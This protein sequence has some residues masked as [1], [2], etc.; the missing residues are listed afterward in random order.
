MKKISMALVA[1]AALAGMAA[2][3]TATPYQPRQAGAASAG[4]YSEARVEQDRWRITFQGNS[5]TSRETVER[6]LLYRAAELTQAQG[7][8]WFEMVERKTDKHTETY[9]EPDPFH[10]RHGPGFGWRPY[11]RYYGGAYGWRNWDPFWGDPFWT[12]TIDVQTVEMYE[13]SAE[14]I[15]RHGGK[16]SGDARAF[17][18]RDVTAS[19]GPRIVRPK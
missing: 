15:M 10:G 2:C 9:A 17:D 11:W 18:V 19:L 12:D 3:Q 5:L 6:Y 16:P 1:V 13:A 4:G 8:D 7:F 14:I